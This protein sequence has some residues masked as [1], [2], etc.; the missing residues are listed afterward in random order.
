MKY[1]ALKQLKTKSKLLKMCD[2]LQEAHDIITKE[3]N[4]TF[5]E[6][7]YRGCFPVYRNDKHTFSIQGAYILDVGGH[8]VCSLDKQELLNFNFN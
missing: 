2:T 4:A 6:F 5:K 1:Q 8:I 3:N 7:S